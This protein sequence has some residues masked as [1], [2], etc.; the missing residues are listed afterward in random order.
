M[1]A[2][3]TLLQK[4]YARI[5]NSFVQQTRIPSMQ[6]LHFFYHSFVY[7]LMSNGIA[8]YHCMSDAYIIEDLVNELHET[9]E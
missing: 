6:A 7:E 2:N 3:P 5:I 9:K 1:N 8:D 4:K